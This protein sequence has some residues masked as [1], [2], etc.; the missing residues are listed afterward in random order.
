MSA[1]QSQDPTQPQTPRSE[2][3]LPGYEQTPKPQ[4]EPGAMRQISA[5]ELETVTLRLMELDY[6]E[7]GLTRD[8]IRK[9]YRDLPE[10]IY[11]RMPSS[12]HYLN[13]EEALRDATD[14]RSRAEG[15]FLG[16]QPDIPEEASVGDG[17]PPAWGGDP[18][19][20][21]D[22]I[23]DGGSAEDTEGLTQSDAN[24]AGQVEGSITDRDR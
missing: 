6:G 23:E 16:A 5:D 15:D 17:G 8:Q 24:D 12:R 21:R 20:T 19:F 14:A 2:R 22:G 11:L 3:R 7:D 13:A 1:Q 10:A 4:A 18:L 9:R